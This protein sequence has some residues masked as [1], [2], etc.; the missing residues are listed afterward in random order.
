MEKKVEFKSRENILRGELFIPK[1]KGPFPAVL[2]FH[3]NGGKGEKYY[4]AGKKFAEKEIVALAFNFSGCGESSGSY[5]EQTH[6]DAFRD[7]FS[8]YEFLLNQHEV[9][10]KRIGLVGGSFGGFIAA[11]ILPQLDIKSLVL[12]SPSA[13]DDP[14]TAKLDMGTLEEEVNYFKN[15]YNWINSKSYENI[16]DF[17]ESLLIV[18]A[19]NDDNVPSNVVDR[20]F[21]KAIRVYKKEIITIKGADHR[22]S[23]PE[24]KNETF[25]KIIDWFLKTL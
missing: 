24:M 22:L 14:I 19:E 8:A 1:G 5:T 15:E 10:R 23:A 25:G 9:D 17:N 18:K 4:E 7:G 16:S 13:H 2:F 11:S 21:E 20:Y 12:L 6:D 3:G